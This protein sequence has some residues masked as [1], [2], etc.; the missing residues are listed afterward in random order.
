MG[1]A[2][3]AKR[4][5]HRVVAGLYTSWGGQDADFYFRWAE[6]DIGFRAQAIEPQAETIGRRLT[7]FWDDAAALYEVLL[8]KSPAAAA[9]IKPGPSQAA[10]ARPTHGRQLKVITDPDKTTDAH[11]AAVRRYRRVHTGMMAL[12]AATPNEY[13]ILGLTF[14]P[15][16]TDPE[17]EGVF[18]QLSALAMQL[19]RVVRPYA[20]ASAR[21]VRSVTLETW[22]LRRIERR[23]AFL[24]LAREEAEALA[25]GAIHQFE[26]VTMKPPKVRQDERERA[27]RPKTVPF[28]FGAGE[29]ND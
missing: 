8:R 11:L 6:A 12:R 22:L 28:L 17:I 20:A 10:E 19:D 15:K 18:G 4:R 16:R 24:Q 13:A 27:E 25:L 7:P 2:P 1:A 9:L 29:G 26:A 3:P 23:D 5:R 14:L 21:D